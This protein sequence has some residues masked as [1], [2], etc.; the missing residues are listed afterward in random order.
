MSLEKKRT[1]KPSV[2]KSQFGTHPDGFNEAE[3]SISHLRNVAVIVI[4]GETARR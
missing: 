1:D 3:N 4:I 2:Q